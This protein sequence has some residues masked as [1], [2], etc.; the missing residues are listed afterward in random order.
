MNNTDGNPQP[1]DPNPY[2][3]APAIDAVNPGATVGNKNPNLMTVLLVFVIVLASLGSLAAVAGLVGRIVSPALQ[4]RIIEQ[5][6]AEPE[7]EQLQFQAEIQRTAQKAGAKYEL[8]NYLIYIPSTIICIVLAIAAIMTLRRNPLGRRILMGTL[9]AVIAFDVGKTV[10]TS[11]EQAEV[12]GVMAET[13]PK[14]FEADPNISEE[15]AKKAGQFMGAFMSAGRII[16]IVIGVGWLLLKSI[17][18]LYTFFYLKKPEIM[19][20]FGT[21]GDTSPYV[22]EGV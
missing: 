20:L 13:M 11:F 2:G 1:A 7:N 5:A 16:A 19:Q 18:Y 21:T 6:E 14:A 4:K 3:D 22:A 10:L 15:K 12:F 8:A 9:L 17:L